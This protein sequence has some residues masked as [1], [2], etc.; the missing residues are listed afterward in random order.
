MVL[1]LEAGVAALVAKDNV[2]VDVGVEVGNTVALDCV[3]EGS[4]ALAAGVVGA[5]A[6]AVVGAV[7]VDI[8]VVVVALAALEVDDVL[9]I[10]AV[11]GATREC[12]RELV[13]ASSGLERHSML[14]LTG[15]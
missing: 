13:L 7:A 14:E 5:V 2:A 9:D 8:H 10:A 15:T 6:A 3:L 1:G 11:G 12:A 4:L